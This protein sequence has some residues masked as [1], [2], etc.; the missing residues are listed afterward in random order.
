MVDVLNS[1]RFIYIATT[2]LSPVTA[3]GRKH[4][5]LRELS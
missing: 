1:G 3:D 4:G 5:V 2:A